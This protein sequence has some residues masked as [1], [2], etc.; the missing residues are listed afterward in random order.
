VLKAT[1]TWY[2]KETETGILPDTELLSSMTDA[3][4]L[5][6]HITQLFKTL[7]QPVYQ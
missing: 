2:S 1:H 3:I 7:R 4:N 5:E 6:Q